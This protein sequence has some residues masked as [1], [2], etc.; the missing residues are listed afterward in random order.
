MSTHG[1]ALGS[2]PFGRGPFG[3]VL[4]AAPADHTETVAAESHT[5]TVPAEDHTEV[6][7]T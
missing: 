5:Q 3:G 1:L 2:L 6:A 4:T 7:P